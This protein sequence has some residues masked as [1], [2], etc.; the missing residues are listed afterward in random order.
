[1]SEEEARPALSNFAS[2]RP[3]NVVRS[4]PET[5][6]DNVEAPSD[7]ATPF[8]VK[9]KAILLTYNELPVNMTIDRLE[10]AVKS[11]PFMEKTWRW[12]ICLER[13]SRVHAHAYFE[14]KKQYDCALSQFSLL[15]DP[16]ESSSSEEVT[17]GPWQIHRNPYEGPYESA[18]SDCQPNA[19][20]G[21]GYRPAADRGHFYV[22]CRYKNTH[23]AECNN[24]EA[25]K[26]FIVKTQWIQTYWQQQKIDDDKILPG[27]GFYRCCT[28]AL[29]AMVRHSLSKRRVE[30]KAAK[31]EERTQVL[32]GMKRPHKRFPEIEAWKEQYN[33]VN[34]RYKFLILWGPTRMGK[35]ELARSYFQ[36][37]YEHRD[38]ICWNDYDADLH[39]VIIFDDVKL[40]Y[41]YIS[42]NRS[43]FQAGSWVT[44]QTS[45]TNVFAMEIDV[46]QKP[47]IVTSNSEPQGEWI[48]GNAV[49]IQIDTPTFEP[50]PLETGSNAQDVTQ[51]TLD[52]FMRP[53]PSSL[54]YTRHIAQKYWGAID[55]SKRTGY[56]PCGCGA[57]ITC[58]ECA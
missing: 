45:A 15:I 49:N 24:Y 46:T 47:I 4:M 31:R 36:N 26:D 34:F 30:L 16:D 50:D 5:G 37:P 27:A 51:T 43:L 42:D 40:V 2:K 14:A 8:T 22:Q 1:M 33:H 41:K 19:I 20:T 53:G 12:S 11:A 9:S 13:G 35:T 25:G 18:V 23:I 28:P 52:P 58:E 6:D 7:S 32:R 57:W 29:E 21:S 48:L 10:T 54:T 38:S 3:L 55:P 44:V 17:Y 39:D 56:K